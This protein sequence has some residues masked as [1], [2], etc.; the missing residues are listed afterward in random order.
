MYDLINELKHFVPYDNNEKIQLAKT[1]EFLQN[2][3]NCYDR[4]NL[5]GHVTAGA[6]VCDRKGNILLNHHKKSGMWFQFGGHC[7]GETDCLNVAK[8]EVMEESGITDI[9]LGVPSIFCVSTFVVADCN[10]KNEPKHT[11][12]D[13][14]FLF[15]VKDKYFKI[16]SESIEIKWT[17]IAEA[18]QLIDADDVG[19][20]LMITKYENWLKNL[21]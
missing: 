17:T 12:Y 18:R 2:N 14:N 20:R 21:K 10:A 7:D 8:R 19:T 13:I 4:S 16:S 9:E 1:L 11:H 3:D 15:I 5:V 6:L